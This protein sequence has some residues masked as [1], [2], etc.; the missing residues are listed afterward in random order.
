MT[1]SPRTRHPARPALQACLLAAFAVLAG[2][3]G[4]APLGP[5]EVVELDT[6]AGDLSG[7]A[8]LAAGPGGTFALSWLEPTEELS[9][10]MSLKYATL[11]SGSDQWSE[12]A[13]L[14]ESEEFFIN[15]AD[16][17]SV[18]PISDS[19]WA[20]H[21]LM[22]REDYEGYDIIAAISRDAG[23]SW[24]EPFT[25]N[26]DATPTEHG[27]VTLFPV[28]DD[29]GAVWLDGRETYVD[30]EITYTSASGDILG[31]TLR[32]ARFDTDGER[33]T[34]VALDTLVCDCCQPDIAL[35]DEGPVLIYRDRTTDEIRDIV[36]RRMI[37]GEWQPTEPLP[38][39][40]W[41]ITGC[42]ING[43]AIAADGDE[44]AAAWFSAAD[45]Q[46]VVHYARSHDD[47]ASF[48]PSIEID[49]AGSFG[50]VDVELLANGDAVVSWLREREDHLVLATRR[51][52]PDGETAPVEVVT[53]VDISRPLDFPQMVGAG[54]RLVFLWTSYETGSNVETGVG[55]YAR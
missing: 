7:Q 11:P 43:P 36:T 52:S 39:D 44:V 16:F 41:H 42:P 23:R 17:P 38:A 40:H 50:Y 21:W 25:L 29:I 19:V 5:L 32:Y 45:E 49:A 37:D 48:G 1:T 35:A 46:P 24:G 47:G 3:C 22:F 28:G 54:D 31:T 8:H 51:V 9:D 6:P 14:A 26:T 18:V 15:W 12:P 55:R 13:T 34:D 10:S 20:A 30:G 27:F 4:E 2:G 53:D 33:L